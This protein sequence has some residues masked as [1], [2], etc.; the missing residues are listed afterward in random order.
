MSGTWQFLRFC[1][2]QHCQRLCAGVVNS[3]L[4]ILHNCMYL[5]EHKY[6]LIVIFLFT[7]WICPS[8]STLAGSQMP[9]VCYY[10]P[11]IHFIISNHSRALCCSVGLVRWENEGSI[12]HTNAPVLHLNSVCLAPWWLTGL[13][14][15]PHVYIVMT[16]TVNFLK[17]KLSKNPQNTGNSWEKLSL[18]FQQLHEPLL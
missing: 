16:S 2:S 14:S 5:S 12:F 4:M 13:S 8:V 1:I 15:L 6:S 9:S 10:R 11:E 17:T 7:P 3:Y 18:I